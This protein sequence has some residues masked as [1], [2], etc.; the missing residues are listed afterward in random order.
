[1]PYRR[2]AGARRPDRRRARRAV[3]DGARR[4]CE[5]CG[6]RCR[7]DGVNVGPNLGA[8]AG[9]SQSDHLHVHCVP[10]WSGD[11]NFMT[12]VAE[13]R[14][15][16]DSLDECWQASPP[17]GRP[18]VTPV[19]SLDVVDADDERDE[20]RDEEVARRAAR[21]SRRGRLRRALRLPEQQPAAHPWLPVPDPRRR[22]PRPLGRRRWRDAVYVNDGFLLAGVLLVVARRLPPAGGV[23]PRRRRA[24]RPG[25]RQQG[26]RLP[27]RPRVGAARLAGLRS[28]PTWRILLYS[29]EEP[30]EQRGL[31]L[32]DGVDGSIV[33]HFVEDN[34]EDWSDLE[35]G[36]SRRRDES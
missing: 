10:R 23:G 5:R 9:G 19:A 34:P 18:G 30:P 4:R 24:R 20:R 32:V 3:V 26:G 13:T 35:G 22:V 21:R 1:M 27:R 6:R 28:K 33:A 31:V 15:L 17:P 11:S 16:P 12:A 7:C 29:A 36:L 8:A 25:R 2:G 14:V